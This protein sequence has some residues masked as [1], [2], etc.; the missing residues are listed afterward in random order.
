MSAPPGPAGYNE[1]PNNLFDGKYT[2]KYC[3]QIYDDII[4]KVDKPVKLAAYS[5]ITAN[6]NVGCGGRIPQK[7]TLY[8]AKT[9]N[10]SWVKLDM[11][12]G[13]AFMPIQDFNET[14]FKIA[15][16]GEY[17]YYKLSLSD[18]S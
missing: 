1:G 8:G 15:K 11:R 7:F 14:I 16:T 17:Q 13:D 12:I 5:L 18:I 2:T 3:T 4:F 6:D 9:E 10:G